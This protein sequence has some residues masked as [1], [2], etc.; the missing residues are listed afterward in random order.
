MAGSGEKGVN[1]RKQERRGGGGRREGK[2][3]RDEGTERPEKRGRGKRNSWR[4]LFEHRGY[5]CRKHSREGGRGYHV[6]EYDLEI[7][8]P[9]S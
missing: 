8:L 5:A 4:R 7:V 3:A 6:S 1:S 2:R 9:V